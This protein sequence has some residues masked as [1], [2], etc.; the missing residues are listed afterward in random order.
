MVGVLPDGRIGTAKIQFKYLDDNT[1][2]YQSTDREV[3]GQ[4]VPDTTVK[5]IRKAAR[6]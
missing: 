5:Y 2:L 1:F 3:D 6:P 4:P